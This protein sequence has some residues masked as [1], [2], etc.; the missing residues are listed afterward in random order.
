MKEFNTSPN[1][2][3]LTS[4]E[5]NDISGGLC[6]PIKPIPSKPIEPPVYITLAIGE[7]GGELPEIIA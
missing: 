1:T 7:G 3:V 2:P 4:E 5:T 6:G